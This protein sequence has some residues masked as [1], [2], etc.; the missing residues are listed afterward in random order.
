MLALG[1]YNTLKIV[2]FVDFGAY[3]DGGDE[4]EILMP[5]KYLTEDLKE[6]DDVE[7]FIYLDS[8]E[9]L[10]ATTE[11]PNGTVGEIC[12]VTIV[13]RN[14]YGLFADWNVTKNIF[15]PYRE[16][17]RNVTVGSDVLIYIYIDELTYR[18]VG[19][20]K[21]EKF[22][23]PEER[24]LNEG[25]KVDILVWHQTPLGY[26][27]IIN[28]S[29]IG[30]LYKNDVF[31]EV[32]TGYEGK[33]YI[34]K[35]REHG[36]IDLTMRKRGYE[37]VEDFSKTLFIYMIRKDGEID[38]NDNSSPDDIRAVFGVSKKVFKKGVGKLLKEGKI[39]ITSNG[40]KLST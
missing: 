29:S 21:L 10:V 2:K 27:C 16:S 4:G 30:L 6:G 40:L 38:L 20:M 33:A 1:E 26:K 14:D 24:S 31:K 32:K 18:I 28:G 5:Q 34:D 3:L 7:V 11:T 13:E 22:L 23:A 17:H 15:I 19:S 39:K 36:K 25:E 8:E 35:I 37:A 12:L 9:R